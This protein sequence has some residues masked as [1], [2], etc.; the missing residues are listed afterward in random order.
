MQG[1]IATARAYLTNLQGETSLAAR[2]A[3]Q[4]LEYLPDVDLVSRSLRTVA[5][6]LLGDASS[7]NGDLE[8]ARHAYSE[9]MQIAQAAGDV[10]LTIVL[11]SNI[12]NILM[13]QGYLHEA[14]NIYSETL[15]M[16]I[17][18]DGQKLVIIADSPS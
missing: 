15:E 12:A 5:T 14:H 10:H 9:A 3:R 2:F 6:S 1:A 7:I 13:E 17:R 16:A 4:A 11:N 8:E 18:P